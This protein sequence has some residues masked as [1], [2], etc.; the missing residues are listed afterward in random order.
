MLRRE[1]IE[2]QAFSAS[3]SDQLIEGLEKAGSR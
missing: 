3:F 1:L 2:R